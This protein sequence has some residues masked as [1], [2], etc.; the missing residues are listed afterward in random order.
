[1]LRETQLQQSTTLKQALDHVIGLEAP[2]ARLQHVNERMFTQLETQ[3]QGIILSWISDVRQADHFSR[4]HSK[5]LAGTG[6]W[7]FETEQFKRWRT[8]STAELLRFHG[9]VGS[10]KSTLL[11]VS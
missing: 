6:Q 9:K 5:A 1:M 11:Y 8:A 3:Q 4:A 10:G 7:F 2:V